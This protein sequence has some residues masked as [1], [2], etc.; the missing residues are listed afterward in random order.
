M[1]DLF[2]PSARTARRE[3]PRAQGGLS[4]TTWACQDRRRRKVVR[5]VF[6]G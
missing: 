5:L 6:T 1:R 4:V 3:T 2:P